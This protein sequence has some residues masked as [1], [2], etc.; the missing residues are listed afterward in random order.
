MDLSEIKAE[1]AKLYIS[2]LVDF[3]NRDLIGIAVCSG[4][5]YGLVEATID[6]AMNERGRQSMEGKSSHFK[7]EFEIHYKLDNNAQT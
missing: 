6:M 4:P 5:I 7:V 3:F 1:G 2:S